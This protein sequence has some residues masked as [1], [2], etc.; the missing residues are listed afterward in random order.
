[1]SPQQIETSRILFADGRKGI[2]RVYVGDGQRELAEIVVTVRADGTR[3]QQVY[4]CREYLLDGVYSFSRLAG[5]TW[6][7]IPGTVRTE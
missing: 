1:M 3:A 7:I 4:S 5:A 2:Q 6:A